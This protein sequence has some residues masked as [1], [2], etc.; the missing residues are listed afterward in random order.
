M[1][2][3]SNN[4]III[5]IFS[6]SAQ[7]SICV[8]QESENRIFTPKKESEQEI[9]LTEDLMREHGALNRILLIYEEIIHRIEQN[10]FPIK[11]LSQAVTI[12]HDFIE[13]YHEKL[14]EEY[15]FP[16]FERNNQ[17]LHLVKTLRK[18]HN[19]GREITHELQTII[20]S[21]KTDKNTRKKVKQLLKAFIRMYRPHEA[22]EDTVIIPKVRSL[23]SK[24]KFKQLSETFEDIEHELFGQKGFF[25][26]VERIANIEKELNIYN[27]EQFTP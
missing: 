2:K 1:K 25:D 8:I 21:H 7:Q 9:P 10:D 12:I 23:L 4:Q 19:K 18:Q 24:K 15:V 17:Q 26:V 6:L 27:L 11:A 13:G 22:C 16:L 20:Q 3:I 14:E 5:L